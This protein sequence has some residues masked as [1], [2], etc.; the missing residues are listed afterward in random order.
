LRALPAWAVTL[1][2]LWKTV[3]SI[4]DALSNAEWVL[5]FV[6]SRAVT[7]LW[8]WLTSQTGTFLTM[9]A[10][11]LWL[12][13]IATRQEK[14]PSVNEQATEPTRTGP[15]PTPEE[16]CAYRDFH[17]FADNDRDHID[18]AVFVES[19]Q[20]RY[21]LKP[22]SPYIDFTF[23]VF[24]GSVYRV[25]VSNPIEGNILFRDHPLS[26]RVQIERNEVNNL[27]R[28]ARA[29]FCVRQWLSTE[30]AA[31][32]SETAD[33]VQFLFDALQVPLTGGDYYRDILPRHLHLVRGVYKNGMPLSN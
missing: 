10:G 17:R 28:H 31:M 9:V 19:C 26:G 7:T 16:E 27:E 2:P 13:F 12:A 18:T 11:L 8:S 21:V 15:L 32:I 6:R 14:R 30:E 4:I 3:Y 22:P 25:S 24:N 5:G 20:P 33:N 23:M 29:K 1:W